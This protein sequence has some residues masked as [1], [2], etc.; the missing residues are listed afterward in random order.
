MDYRLEKIN[1]IIFDLGEVI[2]DLDVKAVIDAFSLITKG[3][4]LNK[5]FHEYS[6]FNDYETGKIDN[7]DFVKNINEVAGA[8]FTIEEIYHIWNLMIKD[9]P[10]SRLEL[11]SSLK[12]HFRVLVLSNTN[13]MH[14]DYFEKLMQSRIG[15]TMKD[16][17][18]KAYY[19]HHM[20]MRKPDPD[21]YQYVLK[22]EGLSP[23]TTMFLDDKSENIEAARKLG[24][25]AH[26]VEF[27]D[28]IFDIFKNYVPS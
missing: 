22:Q 7:E 14:E 13:T 24:I 27:P 10:L 2:V 6:F 9:I 19:S 21:I 3:L 23:E 1:T 5:I 15:L 17:V 16:L 26:R 25:I 18:D 4:D 28:Q 8:N 20:G 12:K 11:I